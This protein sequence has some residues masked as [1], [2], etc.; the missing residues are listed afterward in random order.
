[1]EEPTENDTNLKLVNILSEL[2]TLF[3][4]A[5]QQ[6]SVMFIIKSQRTGFIYMMLYLKP[7]FYQ[8]LKWYCVKY[9][10]DKVPIVL[11]SVK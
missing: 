1:M 3:T 2:D 8:C 4:D 10:T 9:W 6:V 5:I 11:I 7:I